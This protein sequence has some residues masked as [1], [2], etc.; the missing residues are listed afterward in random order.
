ML[1]LIYS[2]KYLPLLFPLLFQSG[3][4]DNTTYSVA[5]KDHVM[6]STRGGYIHRSLLLHSCEKNSVH[7]VIGI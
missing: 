2:N 7:V 5:I 1:K 4:E 3:Y 6:A